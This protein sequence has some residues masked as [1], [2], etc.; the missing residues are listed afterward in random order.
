MAAVAV[1]DRSE[2]Y[3]LSDSE[4]DETQWGWGAVKNWWNPASIKGYKRAEANLLNAF[5]DDTIYEYQSNEIAIDYDPEPPSSKQKKD[6]SFP[7]SFFPSSND[8]AL[9]TDTNACKQHIHTLTIRVK[10]DQLQSFTSKSSSNHAMKQDHSEAPILN[11]EDLKNDG[12]AIEGQ[13]MSKFFQRKMSQTGSC[14]A[15]TLHTKLRKYHAHRVKQQHIAPIV[16][17]HGYGCAGGYYIP[18]V[19]IIYNTILRSMDVKESP[20]IH[21][22]DWL[23][24]GMSTRPEFKCETTQEAEDWFVE[25]L[26]SWR[27]AMNID[28]MILSGHSLGGYMCAVYAIKYPQHI[29]HLVLVS[30]VGV[31]QRPVNADETL[32]KYSW[33]VRTMFKTFRKLWDSGWTPH[34][35]LRLTGPKGKELMQTYV[36]KRLFHL[37][38]DGPL[39]ALLAEYLYQGI[40]QEGSGEYA[41]NKILQPGAW[42]HN[43]L[44]TRIGILKHY[45]RNA[46]GYGQWNI[47]YKEQEEWK[48]NEQDSESDIDADQVLN[49]NLKLDFI[50]GETDWMT[51]GHAVKLKQDGVIQCNVYVNPQ[52]G[53]QLI[54][55]NYKGFGELFGGIVAKGQILSQ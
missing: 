24:N 21:L 17:T 49:G 22:L 9:L 41:L 15:L 38:D 40:G 19:P 29:E 52:C 1:Q 20:V 37:D 34:D 55:E 48:G 30:P 16:L 51:S 32:S 10:P 3:N 42:A 11:Q 4:S 8:D 39:K 44:E 5:L 35:I 25:S 27:K 28:K 45:Q 53:H 50:Y 7:F 26:E 46:K 6:T 14:T 33:K 54:V 13:S 18:S 43:P 47:V 36:Q 31:P 12:N 2:P 23:G